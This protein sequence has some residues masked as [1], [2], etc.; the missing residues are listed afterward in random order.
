MK[1]RQFAGSVPGVLAMLASVTIAGPALAQGA[2]RA[3]GAEASDGDIVVTA[4]RSEE[5]LQDVPISI[6][7]FS[8]EQLA[9]RNIVNTA[10]LGAYTPSLSVNSRFGAEKASFAIRG[11]VQEVNTAPSVGVYFADTVAPR[12]AGGTSGGNGVGVGALFDLQNVQVLKGPQGTLFGR[13]T[14]GGAVLIVPRKPTDSL[15]GYAEVSAGDYELRRVQA[16]LNVPLAE[17]FK[18][19]LGVDRQTR[20]GYQ[21]NHSGIG[22]DRFGDVDYWSFRASVVAD[23]TP[24]L[25]NYLIAS[26]T[27]SDTSGTVPRIVL[28]DRA[29]AATAINRPAG[30]TITTRMQTARLGCAQLDR[31]DARGDNLW[32]VESGHPDPSLKLRQWQVINTTTWRA[33]DTLT[34]KNIASYG[35]YRERGGLSIAGDNFVL[36]P[37]QP[38]AGSRYNFQQ[39]FPSANQDNAAQSTFTE[40]LQFQGQSGALDWQAG[41]YL[42]VSSPLGFSAGNT[43]T[44]AC[45]DPQTFQCFSPFGSSGTASY[46]QIKTTFNNKGVYAQASY[47]LSEA[48]TL[49][50]GLR[51]TMDR[52]R[53]Y[54]QT[55]RIRFPA[56]NRFEYFCS[57]TLRFPGPGGGPRV[58]ASP[59]Q[60]GLTFRVKSEKPTWLINL[61]YKPV[62]DI[63]LYAKYA[64]GYRS[65]GI[66]SNYIGLETWDPEKVDAY[67]VGAKTSFRGPVR[68]YLNVAGFYN[69]FSD[70]Q[71]AAGLIPKPSSGLAGG[72][73]IVN[74]GKSRIYGVE[75]DGAVTLFDSLRFE[76]GYTYL[77]TKLKSIVIPTLPLESPFATI[78]PTA[79]A[80]EELALS[81]K[82][83]VTTTATYT[84]PLDEAIGRISLGATYVYT[85]KQIAVLSS[86]IGVLPRTH[87]LNLNANWANVAGS[88]VDLAFFMTNVTNKA[89]PVNVTNSYNSAGFDGYILNQ[90]RMWGVRLRYSF[91]E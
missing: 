47:D 19:R 3:T 58:V 21:K 12:S 26:Y 33:S 44:L 6:T 13:N 74:A 60:C 35:E 41:A 77:S 39:L 59:A 5:R 36:L 66:A 24:D 28:C 9:N 18:V 49:I 50:G 14:T 31:Q 90:P 73:A 89:Y 11:F 61:D 37:G 64:R 52:T 17:T 56:P 27:R 46:P 75:V 68:G 30:T 10:D 51:Y 67:E 34:I 29:A 54:A 91:G 7:V 1:N 78:T 40:E 76:L 62:E 65:G 81:P 42:E 22:P 23:L 80:G 85:D 38:G 8:Q 43:F 32:D 84:L 55:T 16:V 83:R 15:G 79:R 69:D 20:E 70:Q 88:P 63:M 86:P 57:D 45:T 72:T 87:L 48:L 53:Q 25:E 4:R 82:H 71:L 2:E